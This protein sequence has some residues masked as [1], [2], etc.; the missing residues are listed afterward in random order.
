MGLT[1]TLA[2]QDITDYVD[3]FTI[4]IQST[5][6]NGAGS[7]GGSGAGRSTTCEFICKLGP[8]AS[9][10]GAGGTPS[11]TDLVRQGEVIVTDSTGTV[12][13][14]GYATHFEDE[15]EPQA[16]V[17]KTKVT[18]H[19]YWQDLDRIQVNE[20]YTGATDISIIRDIMTRYAPGIDVSL[21]P[22]T[23]TYSIPRRFIRS[24]SVMEAINKICTMTGWNAWVDPDKKL[25]YVSASSASSAPFGLTDDPD[26]IAWFSYDLLQY[27]TDDT[28][29]INRVYFYGGRK[30]SDDFTQDLQPQANGSNKIFM[31][32]YYPE[33]A[34]DGSI[35]V[36]K[37]GVELT[38]GSPFSSAANGANSKLISDG[39]TADVLV[40]K[41]ARTLT[42]DVAPA[43]TDTLVTIYRYATPLVVVLSDT[44]SH[45]FY[46]RYFDG[47]L[48]DLGV[49]DVATAISRC[50]VLLAQQ[51]FGLTTLQVTCTKGGLQAG[52]LLR[53][54]STTQAIDDVFL[55]QKVQTK[56]LGGG[57]FQYTVDCGAWNWNLIDL[58]VATARD[59]NANDDY[60][61]E[62]LSVVQAQE[63]VE[64]AS[65]AIVI[66][67]SDH[68]SGQYYSRSV[69]SGDGFDA[70]S[71]NF[72]VNT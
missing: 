23:G 21:V 56:P 28:A 18:S 72:T 36:K 29:I 42:F 64:A 63:T 33:D 45:A 2:G 26:F 71:G 54:I 69:A 30:V 57:N 48:S 9:A 58:L 49:L 8:I 25:H 51:S 47:K 59:T 11:G 37:N 5:L 16:L 46:G 38:V 22:T 50:R 66:T 44:T 15:T 67:T 1:V 6:P 7:G 24:Q 19:D 34:V 41:D 14:G 32:A 43:D 65:L 35:H 68:T 10:I 61:D 62:D 13:F 70:Y 40:N 17:V 55:I 20:V 53:V 4:D 31:T 27:T 3:E 60:T 39:G 52:Q 12:I